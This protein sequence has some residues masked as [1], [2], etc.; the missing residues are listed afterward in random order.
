MFACLEEEEMGPREEE[1]PE[2]EAKVAYRHINLANVLG[3]NDWERKNW[4][5]R[6]F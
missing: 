3:G 5:E 4:G 2:N 6:T 1:I